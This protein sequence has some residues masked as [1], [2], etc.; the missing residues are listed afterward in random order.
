MVNTVHDSMLFDVVCEEVGMRWAGL[1]KE[2]LELA[3]QYLK[4]EFGIEFDLPL[5]VEVKMGKNWGEMKK[6]DL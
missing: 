1:I 5:K 3:P 2:E 6:L 4:A